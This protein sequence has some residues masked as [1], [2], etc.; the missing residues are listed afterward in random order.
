MFT[1]YVR[2]TETYFNIDLKFVYR[3]PAL[4]FRDG[5]VYKIYWT[6]R[7]DAYEKR[8]GQLRAPRFIDY[9]GNPFPLKPG[10]TWI[11]IVTLPTEVLDKGSGNWFVQFYAP[12]GAK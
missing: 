7:N 8:T 3:W 6:T 11:H 2:Y 5:K 9:D 10:Q 4:L 1:N 12:L